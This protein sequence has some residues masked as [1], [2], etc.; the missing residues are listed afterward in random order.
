METRKLG[1][2][3]IEVS[4]LGMGCWAIGGPWTYHPGDS[5]PHPAGWSAVE[6]ADSLAAIGAALDAGVTFFDTAAN[7]GAGHS[8]RLLGEALGRHRE[9]VVIATKFGYLVD[10]ETRDVRSDHTVVLQ[11][12]QSD[13]EASLRRLGTDYIDL[14]Q[15]HVG[16]YD[17][18]LAAEI[19]DALEELVSAGKIRTY[20]WSTDSAPGAQVFAQGEHCA[21][22]QFAYNVFAEKYAIRDLLAET[23]LAGIARSPLAMGI[24]TGKMTSE[25]TFPEDD[26]RQEMNFKEGRTAFMLELGNRLQRILTEGGHTPA[27]GALSWILTGDERIV[28][29]PGFK[30]DA[31]VAE[32]LGTLAAGR[33]SA[34]QMTRIEGIRAAW[35]DTVRGHYNPDEVSATTE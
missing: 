35:L 19:R 8:E 9:E 33:L 24:L 6:D 21:A 20:G 29:I 26:V 13:C 3:G 17:P 25:T 11:N 16:D 1:R 34:D 4:A 2:S 31:Q 32:N 30:T 10:E 22:I 7:Y 18:E 23:N 12:L 14:Y 27:Q 28:P 5:E 15:L